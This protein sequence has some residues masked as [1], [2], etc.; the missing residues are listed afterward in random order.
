MMKIS[1]D[2]GFLEWLGRQ[3]KFTGREAELVKNFTENMA[4]WADATDIN[5]HFASSWKSLAGRCTSLCYDTLCLP[6]LRVI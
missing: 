3:G 4:L 1:F 6:S 5:R 2:Q